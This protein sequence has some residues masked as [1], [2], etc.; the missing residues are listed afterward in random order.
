[1]I[2]TLD[3]FGVEWSKVFER[4]PIAKE[5]VRR[6]TSHCFDNIWGNTREEEFRCASNPEA[7]SCG[8]WVTKL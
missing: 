3:I 2:A 5:G 6:P 8:V 4:M 1:M 7:M